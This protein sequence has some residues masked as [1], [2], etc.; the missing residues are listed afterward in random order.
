MLSVKRCQQ[1]KA[2]IAAFVEMPRK[3]GSNQLTRG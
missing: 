1:R 2:K 3:L